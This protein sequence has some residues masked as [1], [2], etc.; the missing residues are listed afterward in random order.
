MSAFPMFP[1]GSVLFPGAALRLQIF[2]PRY[3][4]LVVDLPMH[5]NR[6]G[7][8]LIRRGHEVGGGDERHE[9]GTVAEVVQQEDL[10]DG[11][12][13]LSAVGRE[14]IRVTQ[15]LEDRPYPRA[16]VEEIRSA[17]PSPELVAAIAAAANAR[18]QLLGIAVEMGADGL[19]LDLRLP[20]DPEQAAWA[21][22][23]ESPIGP[24]DRQRLLE[25]DDPVAR[26]GDLESALIARADDLRRAM[27]R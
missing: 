6:F 10:G 3:G 12:Y 16:L 11:L 21:L 9:V 17:D 25:I 22:C 15:W 1:L 23:R 7:V 4:Q 5:D 26:L 14:R 24:F 13:L 19:Q 18:K 2:E 27:D 20:D 8:V